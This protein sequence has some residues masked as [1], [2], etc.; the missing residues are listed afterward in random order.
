M[1]RPPPAGAAGYAQTDRSRRAP[2]ALP[3]PLTSFVGREHEIAQVTAML[4]RADVRLLTL[5]G[6]GGVGK[7]R[8]ALEVARRIDA[9]FADGAVFVRLSAVRDPALA[10]A[11]VAREVGA[12]GRGDTLVQRLADQH[13]LLVLDNVEHLLDPAPLWIAGLLAQCPRLKLLVTSRAT[14]NLSGE[15]RYL[16]PSLPL[17]PVHASIAEAST[18]AIVLFADRA[19]ALRPEFQVD[20]RNLDAVVSICRRVDGLP[21]AIE[22]AASRIVLLTPTE[23]AAHLTDRLRL[24]AGGLRDAPE[25]LRSMR[26]AFDW[27]YELLSSAEQLLFSHLAVFVGGFDLPAAEAVTAPGELD[28]VTGIASLLDKSLLRMAVLDPSGEARYLMSETL[29]EYG[30]ERLAASGDEQAVRDRHADW[31]LTLAGQFA[32]SR[33]HTQQPELDAV[34]RLEPEHGNV[35]AALAWLEASHRDADLML[36][37]MRMRSFWYL[38]ERFTEALR[39]YERVQPAD[40]TTAIDLL[41]MRGQMAQLL[42][43]PD[44]A[45]LL[46][47][48]LARARAAGDRYREADARFHLAIM[49]EDRGD[50][51]MAGEGFR[52]ARALFAQAANRLG[53]TQAAYHL[54]VVAYGL[55]Q[56]DAGERHLR[57]AIG[58]AH[59][60]GD[61]L[62]PIWADTYLILIACERHDLEWA[63]NLLRR[64]V[65]MLRRS[66][67]RHHVP[68]YLATAAVV[69]TETG[70]YPLAARLLGASI[71]SGYQF[72]LP[73][74]TAFDRAAATSRQ[75]LG[76]AEFDREHA[77]GRRLRHDEL[78]AAL[79]DL[80]AGVD[81]P[82]EQGAAPARVTTALT[83]REME[84]LQLLAEG[85]TNQ[86]IADALFVSRRTA[87]THVDH[88]LTKLTVR[89][90]TAAVA[91]AVRHGLA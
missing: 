3:R 57:E 30:L 61:P 84:V 26:A 54:G 56:L 38:T 32:P 23:I 77:I 68:E 7:T 18:D 34:E 16:V 63:D 88:I 45:A 76:D 89:S 8:L 73:E 83:E 4:D 17:P 29:R 51:D 28:V 48:A 36:L 44:A 58:L 42:G 47:E 69:A 70:Q 37:A 24:L 85:L 87:A 78:Q 21:L 60:A 80:A 59:E 10:P 86:E 15:H 64:D 13:M 39:W 82:R 27:S 14:L 46:E 91:Y 25:R 53:A 43:R 9:D 49:A 20:T 72:K 90:R 75:R 79:D 35:R 71:R 2:A 40:E 5:T 67:L 41:R 81:T 65:G 33:E 19:R 74:R 11:A 1:S 31:Y 6:P 66:A 12:R 55:A 52:A 50:F 22:L 62:L